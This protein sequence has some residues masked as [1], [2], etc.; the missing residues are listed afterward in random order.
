MY[1]KKKRKKKKRKKKK[2][3]KVFSAAVSLKLWGMGLKNRGGDLSLTLVSSCTV[4]RVV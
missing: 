1:L 4:R 3:D 2:R